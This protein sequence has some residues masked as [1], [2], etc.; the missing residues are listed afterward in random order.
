MIKRNHMLAT[1]YTGAFTGVPV[2]VRAF[3]SW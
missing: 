2:A 1:R 3:D